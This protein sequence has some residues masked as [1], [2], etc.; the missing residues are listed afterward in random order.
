MAK[1][2]LYKNSLKSPTYAKASN[3]MFAAPS[4]GFGGYYQG[5]LF[6]E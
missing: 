5:W 3:Y 6:A 1:T 4:M 2:K